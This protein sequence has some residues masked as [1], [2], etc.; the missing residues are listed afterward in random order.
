MMLTGIFLSLTI[1]CKMV[2]LFAF[3]TVGT[4]VV[5][6]LWN[7]L[8][9]NRGHSIDHVFKHF[10]A[11]V[12]GLIIVPAIVYLFWFWVHF[13]ILNKSGTGDDFMS[14]AFQQT[15]RDSPLMLNSEGTTLSPRLIR[16]RPN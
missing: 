15:L 7:L 14:S 10:A 1:S 6:D 12:L 3:M 9:I 4:A 5:V 13:T 11:R 8:D 2:G 16:N